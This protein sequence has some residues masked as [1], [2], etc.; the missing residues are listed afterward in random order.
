MADYRE[1]SPLNPLPPVVVA[2]ALLLF[3]IE[4]VFNLGQR[5][6]IGGPEAVG[7]RLDAMREYAFSAAIFDWMM[8]TGRWPIEHLKRFVTYPFIHWSFMHMLMVN[9]F[10]LALGKMVGEVF[11]TLAVLVIFFG[12]SIIAALAYTLLGSE[13]PLVGGYPAAYGMI[14]SYTFMLWL[15]YGA[16]GKSRLNAFQLIA[17][18]VGIQLLFG[19]LFGSNKDWFADIAGFAAGFA[20]SFGLVPGAFG[21]LLDKLRQR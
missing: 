10:L 4:L 14:G 11:G 5:G 21:R 1:E 18:L 17:F 13:I 6:L 7:W 20:L 3:G 8:E 9:V 15:S 16:A 2:L 19:L 12:S